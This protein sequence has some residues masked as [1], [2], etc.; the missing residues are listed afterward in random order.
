MNDCHRAPAYE[1][2]HRVESRDTL[3]SQPLISRGLKSSRIFLQHQL[4]MVEKYAC[5]RSQVSQFTTLHAN[6]HAQAHHSPLTSHQ[7]TIQVPTHLPPPTRP[8]STGSSPARDGKPERAGPQAPRY[9]S[10][11]GDHSPQ[12]CTTTTHR[13]A[14]A[15]LFMVENS[16]MQLNSANTAAPKCTNKCPRTGT[17]SHN[18]A[19]LPRSMLQLAPW[20]SG[21]RS[22]PRCRARADRA[23]TQTQT[24]RAHVARRVNQWQPLTSLH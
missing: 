1:R 17:P 12:S 8:S 15:Q 6:C 14:A 22:E 21:L 13:R 23:Q 10:L 19:S 24:S 2:V 16:I 5:L 3:T 9:R 20:R 18:A 4:F 11:D 7:H